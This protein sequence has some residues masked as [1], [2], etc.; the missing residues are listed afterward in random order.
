MDLSI[1]VIQLLLNNCNVIVVGNNKD[2]WGTTHP[3]N[4]YYYKYIKQFSSRYFLDLTD[5]TSVQEAIAIIANSNL[6]ICPD[7]GLLHAANAVSVPCIGLFGNIDPE[8]RCSYYDNV[9]SIFK[10]IPCAQNC[11]DRYQ[12]MS[13]ICPSFSDINNRCIRRIGADCMRAISPREIFDLAAEMLGLYNKSNTGSETG[14]IRSYVIQFCYGKGV[15]IGAVGAQ[16]ADAIKGDSII[17]DIQKGREPSVVADA[18]NLYMFQTDSFDYVY[19]SHLLEDLE[20]NDIIKA[21]NEW[22]R[23]LKYNGNMIIYC[24]I[25]KIYKQHCQ[26]TKQSLNPHHKETQF[27]LRFLKNKLQECNYKYKIIHQIKLINNYS[28]LLVLRKI[29]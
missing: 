25:Q 23:V 7:T 20:G 2:I 18:R 1:E 24:P 21:L 8:L 28:F 27:S 29:M 12:V 6:V 9:R 14:R 17:V 26:V 10:S 16:F 19:S 22:F 5:K 4:T 15:D 3:F 11:G 13:Q